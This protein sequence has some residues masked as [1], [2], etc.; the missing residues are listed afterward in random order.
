MLCF[1]IWRE[2][3]LV[4]KKNH[5]LPPGIKWSAPKLVLCLSEQP[6]QQK[7]DADL[8]LL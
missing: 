6:T 3:N 5:T 7:R 2:N 8:M 4:R 1:L